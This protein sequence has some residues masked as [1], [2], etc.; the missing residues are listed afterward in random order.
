MFAGSFS[1]VYNIANTLSSATPLL[2][3][4]LGVAVAFKAG[5]ANIGAEGQL[6]MGAIVSAII[7]IYC[8]LPAVLLLPLALLGSFLAGGLYAAIPA[9]LKVKAN[10]NEVVTTLMLNYVATLFTSYLANYPLK[11]KGAPLG[12]TVEI[13]NAA[14]LPLLYQGSRFNYGFLLA[15]LAAIL[16]ALLFKYTAAGYEMRMLGQNGA[17]S[18]YIGV[19]VGRRMIQGMFLG[20]GLAGGGRRDTGFR[21][22]VQVRT[23]HFAR[24]RV[25]W[26]DYCADGR[27]QSL[28]CY[29]HFHPIS[30]R[31]ARAG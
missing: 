11:A 26:P 19:N 5:V 15:I 12:M 4:G 29:P 7:G 31:Y 21:H 10:T 16:V 9:V 8:K 20:G 28:C 18:K 1:S 17:F 23:E 24:L 13:Q 27:L 2:F 25:R 14:K 3:A 6:Y 22:P 30:A